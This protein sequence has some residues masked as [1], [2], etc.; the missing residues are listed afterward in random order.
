MRKLG[1]S[2]A[3]LAGAAAPVAAQRMWQPEIG[4]RAGFTRFDDP[5]SDD[6]FDVIDLPAP[7]GIAVSAALGEAPLYGII[8]VSDRLAVQPT[9]GFQ[10]LSGSSTELS[11]LIAG[12]RLNIAI[13]RSFYAGVGGTAYLV[14]TNGL[15][16]TEGAI[17][18][19]VGYRHDFGGRFRGSAELFYEKREQSVLLTQVNAFG[20]RLGMGY[21]LGELR[22]AGRAG[23]PAMAD[24][25][26][27]MWNTSIGLQGGWSLISLPGN[28]SLAVLSLPFGGQSLLGGA[29]ALP[30]PSTFSMIFPVGQKMA[31]E[32]SLDIHRAQAKDADAV[33]AFQVGARINYAFN[34]VTYA[35]VGLEGTS[36]SIKGED[37][38]MRISPLVAAGVRFPLVGRMQGRTELNF[39]VTGSGGGDDIQSGQITSFVFG[40]LVPVK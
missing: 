32:P 37:H 10:N 2:L 29:Q 7:G 11:A 5:N 17:E 14:K 8:P 27:A 12:V 9:F 22:P 26:S 3:L 31:F 16:D 19:A 1:L 18:G 23:R 21:A 25:S 20:L 35:G 28:T 13:T 33:T 30:G 15:E 39:R 6:Y 36:I 38:S 24:R 40:I 4:I 34:H